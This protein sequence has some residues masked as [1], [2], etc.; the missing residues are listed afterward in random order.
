MALVPVG[1]TLVRE[2]GMSLQ[3]TTSVPPSSFRLRGFRA[4]KVVR[5]VFEYLQC[6]ISRVSTVNSD[7]PQVAIIDGVSGRIGVQ[8]KVSAYSHLHQHQEP[9]VFNQ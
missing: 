3:K 2:E 7:R 1:P 8:S 9:A 6:I 4:F 5:S